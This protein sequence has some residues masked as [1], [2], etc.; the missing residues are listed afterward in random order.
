M[1]GPTL[2]LLHVLE[3]NM[4]VGQFWEQ[5]KNDIPCL[6]LNRLSPGPDIG[7]NSS[8]HQNNYQK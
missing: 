7:S 8:I 4:P 1:H 6:Q 3:E 5:A 2:L